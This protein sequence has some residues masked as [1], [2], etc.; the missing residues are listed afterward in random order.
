[1]ALVFW[2]S[3]SGVNPW[4]FGDLS[5]SLSGVKSS[6]RASQPFL[7]RL[8]FLGY[9]GYS[10]IIMTPPFGCKLIRGVSG[11][12]IGQNSP[13]KP[14]KWISLPVGPIGFFF[15]TTT[16]L[17]KEGISVIRIING[18]GSQEIC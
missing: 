3:L 4:F 9:L 10:G 11:A 6:G 18:K 13:P 16:L 17:Y 1:M 5:V 15:Q 14:N 7:S 2:D 12:V 8:G